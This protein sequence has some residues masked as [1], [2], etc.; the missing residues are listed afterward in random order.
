MINEKL[1]L[2]VLIRKY[3]QSKQS[4]YGKRLQKA[5]SDYYE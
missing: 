4:D 2:V 1:S 3:F 5:D